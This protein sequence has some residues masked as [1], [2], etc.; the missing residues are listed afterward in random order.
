MSLGAP[1]T[2][3]VLHSG[4]LCHRAAEMSTAVLRLGLGG[5]VFNADRRKRTPR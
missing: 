1:M 3:T 2:R 4:A 5:V